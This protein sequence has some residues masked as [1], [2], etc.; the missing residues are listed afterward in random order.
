MKSYRKVLPH[1]LLTLLLVI[2]WCL[3]TNSVHLGNVILAVILGVVIP[4]MTFAYWPDAPHGI[5]AGTH[6]D[7]RHHRD[8][9]HA[10]GQ[11]RRGMDR[12]HETQPQDGIDLGRRSR[13]TSA[14]PRRS[15]SSRVRSP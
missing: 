1:P 4:K 14:R 12:A 5:K 11:R 3:L 7:L 13:S 2:T 10:P 9:G 8:L 6:G 15:P